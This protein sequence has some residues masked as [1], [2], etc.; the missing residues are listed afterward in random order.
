[1]QKKYS[2]IITTSQWSTFKSTIP[3][4]NL[5]ELIEKKKNSNGMRCLICASKYHLKAHCPE[6]SS[7]TSSKGSGSNG[8]N[9]SNSTKYN[10]DNNG[11]NAKCWR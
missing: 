1:M 9:G 7:T 3:T 4:S 2:D 5:A 8:T 10:Q 11:N 6:A